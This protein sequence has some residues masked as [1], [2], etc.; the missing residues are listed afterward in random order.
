MQTFEISMWQINGL[1]HSYYFNAKSPTDTWWNITWEYLVLYAEKIL[2]CMRVNLNID[3]RYEDTAC[4]LI[5]SINSKKTLLS[6]GS[7]CF[8][9]GLI[10]DPEDGG[11]MLL[12][13]V[14]LPPNYMA[15]QPRRPH[16]SLH[17]LQ[18]FSFK[19][20]LEN[21]EN[22]KLTAQLA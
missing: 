11:D 9:L 16:S 10:F 22:S 1:M 18:K 19:S 3:W 2:F 5:S 14:G 17:S 12:R 8:F 7:A 15:L 6:A 13:N 4:R 20:P 21:F